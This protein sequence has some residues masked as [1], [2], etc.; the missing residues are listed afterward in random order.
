VE[1]TRREWDKHVTR[2]V[3]ISRDMLKEHLQDV[4]K[5]EGAI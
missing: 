1:R 2:I 3:K 5:E 4:R